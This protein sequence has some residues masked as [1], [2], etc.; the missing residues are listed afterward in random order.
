[1]GVREGEIV[2]TV[3]GGEEPQGICGSGLVDALALCLE[4]GLIDA[5]GRIARAEEAPLLARFLT[6]AN[7]MPAVRIAGE[8]ALTQ[9]DIREAQTAKAAISAGIKTLLKKAGKE[10][11]D[12][13]KVYLAGGFGNFM[14]AQNAVKIGMLPR[15]PMERILP[16]GN[17]AGAGAI[18]ALCSS[19]RRARLKDI[20]RAAQTVDLGADPFFMEQYV[21][22]MHFE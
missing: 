7:G 15:F 9:K 21:Q 17:A 5:T 1:V 2:Y 11:G 4:T 20:V 12:V 14:D 18:L 19:E 16:V 13:Q 8:L 22:D 6:S 10:T 3:I